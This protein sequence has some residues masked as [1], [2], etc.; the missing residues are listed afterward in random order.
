MAGCGRCKIQL[1][2]IAVGAQ[3]KEAIIQS[4]VRSQL[5]YTKSYIYIPGASS[6]PAI[7]VPENYALTVAVGS[8][9]GTDTNIQKITVTVF[10]DSQV[11]LTV[12][13]YKV[14]RSGQ[15]LQEQPSII[16]RSRLQ[17]K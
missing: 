2:E 7:A 5:E 10:R 11:L 12:S 6:Y 9:P 1:A 3:D 13:D 14:N 8:V 17:G 16:S 15:G 4:L